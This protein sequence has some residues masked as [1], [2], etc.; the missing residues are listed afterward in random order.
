MERRLGLNL[1]Q[2][3]IEVV[4]RKEIGDKWLGFRYYTIDHQYYQ[5]HLVFRLL[6]IKLEITIITSGELKISL[7]IFK[8]F[9]SLGIG[10]R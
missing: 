1:E 9:I 2:V 6:P 4:T 10:V 7:N 3:P 5:R 8:L